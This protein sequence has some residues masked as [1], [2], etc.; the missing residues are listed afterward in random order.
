MGLQPLGPGQ[1]RLVAKGKA[2][3]PACAACHG[4]QGAGIEGLAP[5][6]AGASWVTGPPEWLGR[7]ILQGMTGP[8]EVKGEI[9]E[10]LMPPHG[11]VPELDDATLAGLMTFLRRSW[12]NRADPVSVDEVAAIRRA[13]SE[14]RTPWT[15]R[16]LEEVPY[17]RGFA[18]F[19]GRYSL[20]FVTLTIEERPEGL[21][22]SAPLYGGA[23]LERL[24]E[25]T[26]RA[27]RAG[28]S[29][30]LEFV[31]SGD[32]TIDSMILYRNGEKLNFSR[33][34]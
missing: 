32:G 25:S 11:D 33:K 1:L 28:E 18:R 20:S 14:R 13:S 2:F 23:L 4:E 5:P 9:F 34:R 24:G 17:D 7:I 16:E 3:Y 22:V 21:F 29:L 19:E 27:S 12:G 30:Q 26:F 15:A 6:L 8:V 31:A 10:G